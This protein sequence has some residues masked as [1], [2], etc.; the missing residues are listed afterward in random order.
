MKVFIFRHAEKDGFAGSDPSLTAYGQAQA[1]KIL[2]EIQA[3]RM[4]APSKLFSSPKK[5]A[6]QTLKAVEVGCNLSLQTHPELDERSN[7]ES[8]H[9]FNRRIQH[10]LT[11]LEQLSGLIYLVTHMD[12]IHSALPLIHCDLDL[13]NER[14]QAWPPAQFIEFEI[15]DRLWIFQTSKQIIP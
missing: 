6:L 10:Y 9:T 2:Q 15:Q 5:R 12:W 13:S 1:Q 4:P 3:Q 14:F 11:H 8:A 7:L